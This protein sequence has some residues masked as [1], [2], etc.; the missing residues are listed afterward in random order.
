M[1]DECIAISGHTFESVCFAAIL[2]LPGILDD[3]AENYERALP[4]ALNYDHHPKA[5]QSDI[6]NRIIEFYFS[7]E[8][9]SAAKKDNITNVREN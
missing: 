7:G 2:N 8:A 3:F 1:Q 9:P 4:I 5:V 6:T